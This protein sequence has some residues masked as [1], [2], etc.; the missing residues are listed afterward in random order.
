M[1]GVRHSDPGTIFSENSCD[2]I[3]VDE[4][5]RDFDLTRPQKALVRGYIK[6]GWQNVSKLYRTRKV[7][8]ADMVLL[9]EVRKK[10]VA[11]VFRCYKHDHV[12]MDAFGTTGV[13]SDYDVSLMGPN[14]HLTMWHMFESFVAHYRSAL[15]IALDVGLYNNGMYESSQSKDSIPG[16]IKVPF[17]AD[18]RYSAFTMT[19]ADDACRAVMLKWALVKVIEGVSSMPGDRSANMQKFVLDVLPLSVTQHLHAADDA[20]L[21]GDALRAQARAVAHNFYRHEFKFATADG[22]SADSYDDS[23][24]SGYDDRR[25]RE[26]LDI[27]VEYGLQFY[28]AASLN[29]RLYNGSDDLKVYDLQGFIAALLPALPSID[30]L[31]VPELL[32]LNMYFSVEAAYTQ[33]T[34]NVVVHEMQAKKQLQFDDTDYLCTLIENYGELLKHMVASNAAMPERVL[35]FS[36]YVY[37]ILYAGAKYK[38][39]EALMNEARIV[40]D[41][42]VSKRDEPLADSSVLS[43]VYYTPD[44]STGDYLAG[45]AAKVRSS[46]PDMA[47]GAMSVATYVPSWVSLGCVTLVMACLASM[48]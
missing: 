20:I 43:L 4:L 48:K 24:F 5:L 35:K 16:L 22:L 46:I 25:Y 12:Y 6:L 17:P 32:C 30:A 47:G 23:D 7:D 18:A 15:P 3:D 19:S 33:A 31:S 11:E 21:A 44:Q 14:S 38:K 26:F 13:T 8:K 10:M 9:G 27:V 45:L 39:D 42:V 2:A 29:A 36:K 1:D 34:V 40:R 37:R 28:Y 41:Q